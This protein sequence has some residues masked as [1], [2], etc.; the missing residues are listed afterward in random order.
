MDGEGERVGRGGEGRRRCRG[1]DSPLDGGGQA[2]GVLCE[3]LLGGEL[4]GRDEARR[5]A[6]QEGGG[7]GE[8]DEGGS[9][10]ERW[11]CG[12][13][14]SHVGAGRALARTSSVERTMSDELAFAPPL[15]RGKPCPSRPAPPRPRPQRSPVFRRQL[16]A[17]RHLPP[18]PLEQAPQLAVVSVPSPRGGEQGA[19]V[20]RRSAALRALG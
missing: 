7:R 1:E 9:R 14:L 5:E 20:P 13:R 10:A 2:V 15:A 3:E 8:D 19:S 4:G 16:I 6:E 17:A 18:E 12:G 11:W